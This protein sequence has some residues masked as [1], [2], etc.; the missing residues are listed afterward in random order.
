[1]KVGLLGFE[2]SGKSTLFAAT[3]K[4]AA[5]GNVAS[6]PVPDERFDTIVR[7]VKP[8]KITPATVIL[9]DDLEDVAGGTQKMFTQRLLDN[10]RKMDVLLL[11]IRKFHS[12]TV[13]YFAEINARRDIESITVE[14]VLSDLQIVENRLERLAKSLHARN[15]GHSE[16]L[17]RVL[18]E[19]LKTQLEAGIP[20]SNVSLSPDNLTIVRNYQFL[21]AKPLIVAINA[22]ESEMTAPDEATANLVAEL[23]EKQMQTFIVCAEIEREI[24]E[25]NDADQPEFLA[26]L[27]LTQAASVRLIQSLYEGL[28][29][30]TF[31]TAGENETRAWSIPKGCTALKAAG[32]IHTDIAKGFIRAEVVHYDDYL[33]FGSLDEAYRAGKMSLQGKDYVVK[34]GDLLHIRNKT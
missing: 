16:Y 19:N 9:H 12:P 23:K 27:G 26:S 17:E 28:G 21:S 8:K 25:L 33:L 7:Q 14:L 30:I 6:V 18:F 4:G 1:M 32:T 20:I 29:L 2:A 22:D 10:A 11:V 5:K 13:P 34:D 3:S 31:F 24:A 15:P